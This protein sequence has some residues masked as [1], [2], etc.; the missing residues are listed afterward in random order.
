[1]HSDLLSPLWNLLD[2]FV[3]YWALLG[4]LSRLLLFLDTFDRFDA[5]RIPNWHFSLI[6]AIFNYFRTFHAFRPRFTLFETLWTTLLL[7]DFIGLTKPIIAILYIFVCFDVA[8]LYFSHFHYFLKVWAHSDL[9][10]TFWGPLD[11][12]TTYWALLGWLSRLLLFLDTFGH[13][14]AFRI[15]TLHIWLI[16]AI[17]LTIFVHFM[18]SDLVSPFLRPFGQICSLLGFIGLNNQIIA[19]FIHIC[20]LWC[21]YSLFLAIFTPSGTFWHILTSFQPFEAFGQFHSLLSFIELT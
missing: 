20:L 8:I 5:F 2:S 12:F 10:S 11:S 18:H 6:L 4:W 17:F 19:I 3:P 13:F 16:L 15:L 1:M 9:I 14:D 7:I 21:I